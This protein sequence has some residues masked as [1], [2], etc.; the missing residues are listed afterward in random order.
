MPP[1]PLLLKKPKDF[2]LG[3]LFI[4]VA[5]GVVGYALQYDLGST[6]QMGPGYFPFVL[7]LILCAFGILLV[8]GSLTG[9]REPAEP[10][11]VRVGAII[12]GA[13]ALFGLLIRPAGLI[14]SALVLVIL[15]ALAYRPR[16]PVP[17]VIY[18]AALTAGCVIVFPLLLGQQ[19]P[20]LGNWFSK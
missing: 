8:A 5:L 7:G 16:R 4:A 3:I 6:W 13:A 19:I 11:G 18:A 12:L 2:F 17:L 10:M 15:S 1:A 20:V 9:R 14:V